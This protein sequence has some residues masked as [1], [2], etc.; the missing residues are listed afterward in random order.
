MMVMT[1]LS[2][3]LFFAKISQ[4]PRIAGDLSINVGHKTT[5]NKITDRTTPRE[6]ETVVGIQESTNI[7]H[8]KRDSLIVLLILAITIF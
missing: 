3:V 2:T 5:E 6:K 4:R 7:F 8:L 1:V